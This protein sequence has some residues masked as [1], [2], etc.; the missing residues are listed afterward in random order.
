[1]SIVGL[2]CI[3]VA[4]F[5]LALADP[6]PAAQPAQPAASANAPAATPAPAT[7]TSAASPA[8]A[9]AP[10]AAPAIDPR[11]QRLLSLGYK[12]QM[13]KGEKVFCKREPILGSRTEVVTRCG[14]VEQLAAEGHLSREVTENSQRTQLNPTGH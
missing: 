4:G 7:Q 14:T 11:E 3:G 13:H 8:P 10:A 6:P 1:M 5:T 12:P 2:V 9:A